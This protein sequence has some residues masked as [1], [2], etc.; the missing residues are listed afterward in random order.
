MLSGV[1]L[2]D[3]ALSVDRCWLRALQFSVP[4]IDLPSVLLSCNCFARIQKAVMDQSVSKP[5]NSD[6]DLFFGASLAFGG[7]LELPGTSRYTPRLQGCCLLLQSFL[8]HRCTVRSLAVPWPS[9]L[10][11]LRVVSDA[12]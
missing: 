8:N 4:L 11:T 7:A 1:V 12:L 6:Q 9:A 3:W 5:P 2:E 10:L